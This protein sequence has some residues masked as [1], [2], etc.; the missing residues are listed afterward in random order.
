MRVYRPSEEVVAHGWTVVA[1][2]FEHSGI[3]VFDKLGEVAVGIRFL[4]LQDFFHAVFSSAIEFN[5]PVNQ[6]A[7]YVF[8]L[9]E[10]EFVAHS[11]ANLHEFFA[12]S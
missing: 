3:V 11:H 5:F 6:F 10:V 1:R 7:V 9:R 2:L 12:I 4:G 8:P